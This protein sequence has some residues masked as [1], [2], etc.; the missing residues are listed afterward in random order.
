MSSLQFGFAQSGAPAMGEVGASV[1][2]SN[3]TLPLMIEPAGIAW[4]PLTV[5]GAGFW[6]GAAWV[7]LFEQTAVTFAVA[8]SVTVMSCCPSPE[9]APDTL[10]C[11]PRSVNDGFACAPPFRWTLAA[12]ASDTDA[13]ATTS[14][15]KRV[16]SRL[17]A[18]PPLPCAITPEAPQGPPSDPG[19]NRAKGPF[20]VDLRQR[21]RF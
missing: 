16:D 3:G 2:T 6:P 13:Q 9:S 7:P 8:V 4:L 10:S 20:G 19:R 11:V 12:V 14:T 15:D 1:V 21:H 5:I 18:L 17:P